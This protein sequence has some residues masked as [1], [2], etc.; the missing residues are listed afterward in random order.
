[1]LVWKI[2][3]WTKVATGNHDVWHRYTRE[4]FENMSPRFPNVKPPSDAG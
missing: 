2:G 3:D 4:Q 1:M